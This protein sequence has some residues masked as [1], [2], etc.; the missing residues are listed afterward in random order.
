[1]ENSKILVVDDEQ[2]FLDTLAKRLRNRSF[3]V[4]T[5]TS[6]EHALTTLE[7]Y[8][9]D[10]VLLDVRMPGMGGIETL[11][12]IKEKYPTVEAI[13]YTGYADTKTAISVMEIGAFDY[14][15][16]PVPIDELVY[17]LQDAHKKRSL[18]Q[19]QNITRQC[20]D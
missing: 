13:I 10:V 8:H 16:K 3:E 5:A 2:E 20:D 7:N 14:L 19:Q 4:Q 9:A 17:K 18:K 15:V 11:S 1:V 6:G 12:A